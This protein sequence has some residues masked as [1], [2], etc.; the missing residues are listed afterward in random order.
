MSDFQSTVDSRNRILNRLHRRLVFTTALLLAVIVMLSLSACI[1]NNSTTTQQASATTDT[2]VQPV[3]EQTTLPPQEAP[4]ESTIED[5]LA[6]D[7]H[8]EIAHT[9]RFTDSNVDIW[10]PQP[11]GITEVAS[12]A[13]AD[14]A[15]NEVKVSRTI[16]N[17]AVLADALGKRHEILAQRIVQ[18]KLGKVLRKDTEIFDYESNQVVTVSFDASGKEIIR[19]V[20]NDARLYQPPESQAE[21][22]RAIELAAIDLSKQG[23]TEHL[24]LHGTGLLAYPGTAESAATGASFFSQRKI[25]VTF[26]IGNGELPQYRAL[27]NLSTSTV[28]SSGSIQ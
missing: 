8:T 24:E 17:T 13:T 5:Q 20:S 2:T 6:E 28:E 10:P 27:V 12:I 7:S 14:V 16:K 18:D 23:F 3:S 9:I 4:T 25:Y 19:W 21:V 26:G 11:E 22:S 15:S 1:D